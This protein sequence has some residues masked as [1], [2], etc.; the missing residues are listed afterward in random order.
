MTRLVPALAAAAVLL[1]GCSA[2]RL[3]VP[4]FN[5]ASSDQPVDR[6]LLQNLASGILA[7]QRGGLTGLI[8]NVGV[9]GRESYLYTSSEPRNTTLFLGAFPLDNSGFT[10]GQ[11]DPRFRNAR[12]ALEIVRTANSAGFLSDAEELCGHF[13][14]GNLDRTLTTEGATDAEDALGALGKFSEGGHE[15]SGVQCHGHEAA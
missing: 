3:N 15:A 4:N 7:E 11:W 5:E 14:V 1:A 2:D 8:S 6:P 12:N 13:V 10:N 9:L